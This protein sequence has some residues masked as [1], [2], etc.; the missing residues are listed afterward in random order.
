MVERNFGRAGLAET[1]CAHEV[2]GKARGMN[3]DAKPRPE[4]RERADMV[5]MG[6][7]DHDAAEVF[8]LL[9]EEGEVRQDEVDPGRL[10]AREGQAAI[11]QEPLAIARRAEAVGRRVHADLAEPAER[12]EDE[13]RRML[14]DAPFIDAPLT[15]C[16]LRRRRAR[17]GLMTRRDRRRRASRGLLAVSRRSRPRSSPR[18]KPST[19][20]FG[21]FTRTRE[22][23]PC[24]RSPRRQ[25][26]SATFAAPA[27]QSEKRRANS[28]E[29]SAKSRSAVGVGRESP[30]IVAS[31]RPGGTTATLTP[32]PMTRA[33]PPSSKLMAFEKKARAFLA[34]DREDRSA[35]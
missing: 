8:A 13:E 24:A 2:D 12:N 10:F 28:S 11:D 22:P 7:S 35:I 18:N 34:V 19:S 23:I 31:G 33:K 25:N 30:S 14:Q 17:L 3:L 1:P 26:A 9:L 27:A 5:L 20:P 21:S 32:M 29:R 16:T 15:S 4:G 6:V